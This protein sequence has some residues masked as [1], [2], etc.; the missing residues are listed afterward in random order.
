MNLREAVEKFLADN[1]TEGFG[2][3]CQPKHQCGPCFWRGRVE[4]PLR[5][6][7]ASHQAGDR[8]ESVTDEARDAAR[9]DWLEAH[10]WA[11]RLGKGYQGKPDS[12][13]YE[14]GSERGLHDAPN[15]RAAIDAA[16]AST[17]P[18]GTQP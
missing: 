9:L 17:S 18:E 2:C 10:P 15:L 7:L 3:A 4:D 16:I 5:R 12:W 8:P 6:I 13:F 1:D 14:A 11:V